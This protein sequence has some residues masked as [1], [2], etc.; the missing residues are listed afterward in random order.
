MS[1]PL[2]CP[3]ILLLDWGIWIFLCFFLC[4]IITNLSGLFKYERSIADKGFKLQGEYI[5]QKRDRDD[6]K[7]DISSDGWYAQATYELTPKWL[8]VY[9]YEMYNP[10]GK[11]SGDTRR[12]N[13]VG[14]KY[15]FNE[16]TSIQM[17]Y[18]AK[19]YPNSKDGQDF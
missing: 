12:I 7:A 4:P 9:K 19:K 11:S 16:Y 1:I 8:S 10:S 18:R 5:Q 17:D 6:Q 2:L 14:I 3:V 13:T 15:T